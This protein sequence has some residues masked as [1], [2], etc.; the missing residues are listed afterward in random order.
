MLEKLV[1][2][3]FASESNETINNKN[4]SKLII[5]YF[6]YIFTPQPRSEKSVFK[7]IKRKIGFTSTGLRFCDIKRI[8]WIRKEDQK[9]SLL[10]HI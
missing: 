7:G 6:I 3:I 5:N 8:R 1:V 10:D 4:T 9:T 2:I